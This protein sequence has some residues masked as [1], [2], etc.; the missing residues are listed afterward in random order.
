MSFNA[1]LLNCLRSAGNAACVPFL[2]MVVFF[3]VA[4]PMGASGQV[5]ELKAQGAALENAVLA[6]ASGSRKYE[7]KI[8]FQ[9]PALIRYSYHETDQKGNTT[10]YAYEFNLADIDP[11]AVREQTQKDLISVAIAARNKQKLIKVYKNEVVQ[12]YDEQ[13]AIIAKDIDNARAMAEIIKKAIPL[14]EKVMSSRLKLS[15][16]DAMVSWLMSNVREVSLGEKSVKQSLTQGEHP[17]TLV[18][19]RVE[20]DAKGAT[21][22]IFTFN[23]ADINPHAVVYKIS[24][25]QFAIAS[26]SLQKAKYIGA[27]KNKEVRPYTHDLIILT[28][29][30]DE[31]RDLKH[32]LS[33]VVPLAVE[34]VKSGMPVVNLDKD[35]IQKITNLTK[36]ISNG[37]RQT[38][39]SLEGGCLATFT[40]V[41]K[42]PKSS[43][44]S[45]YKFNWMD[46]HSPACKIEVGGDK[47]FMDLHFTGDRKL[48][49]HT[50]DEKFKGY[51]NNV[52]IYMPDVES[53]RRAK[54]LVDQVVDKC[55]SS[56]KEPFGN[57]LAS[58]SGYFRSQ[59]GEVTLDEVTLKQMIAPVDGDNNKYKFTVVEVN[60]KGAGA[61]HLYEFNL[62]DI[63]PTSI[64]PDV[65][66]RW[67]YVVL[68]TNFKEKIIKYYKDGKIQPYASGLQFAVNDVE[69]ARNLASALDKAVKAV[70]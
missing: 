60:A 3:I 34:K 14:A 13:T 47:I 21:E 63:S 69:V 26:E 30:A 70:K 55:K 40:Q 53:A 20:A 54:F 15:G 42:D 28:N 59:I 52:K 50:A 61:E 67:L 2:M 5:A 51:D 43:K 39:Q 48:V 8:T 38:L 62:S 57:D 17:G 32:V 22:E 19:T 27:T 4:K 45:V 18:L 29:N 25:N 35:G 41:E 33:T 10:Q 7:Q 46:L 1:S 49:M 44:K 37:D 66:G 56:Y 23:L 31:A 11:Y 65:R 24:G 58:T 68:E 64:V 6:V 16:Y 9:E 36:D 12:P